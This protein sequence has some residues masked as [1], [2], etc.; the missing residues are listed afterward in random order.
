MAK[1]NSKSAKNVSSHGNDDRTK[2]IQIQEGEPDDLVENPLERVIKP[3]QNQHYELHIEAEGSSAH[4]KKNAKKK[5]AHKPAHKPAEKK[6]EKHKKVQ[7]EDF[8]DHL[9]TILQGPSKMQPISHKQSEKKRIGLKIWNFLEWLA[10]SALIFMVAFFALNW[11]SYSMLIKSKLDKATGNF[12]LNPFIEEEFTEA[13]QPVAQDLLSPAADSGDTSKIPQID[14]DIAP[15]DDRIIIPRINKNVPVIP[16]RTENLIKRDWDALE[17]DI[18]DALRGGVVHF[19]GTAR[20][21]QKGNVVITGHSSYFPWDPGRFK[22]VFA[23]LH[24]IVV[25]DQV[26]VYQDQQKVLYEVYE[27]R[28]VTPDQVEVLTQEG[29][30]RLTLLTC[31]P[32]G[33]NLKRLVIFARPI[34]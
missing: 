5:S 1:K 16:V 33:T 24:E 6:S 23:L 34:R 32:V 25:G 13:T 29:D 19:P 8:N 12:Q 14:I 11:S 15:P 20:A 9:S 31:T 27:T 22:D 21:G 3:G 4:P 10:V 26:V 18:Q 7:P 2:E 28:V 17:G 30:D